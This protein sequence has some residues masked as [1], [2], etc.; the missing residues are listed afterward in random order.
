M[1]KQRGHGTG[2]GLDGYKLRIREVLI[3]SGWI[4]STVFFLGLEV[5]LGDIFRLLSYPVECSL[6]TVHFSS[7]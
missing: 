5:H 4:K 3:P 2:K 7:H 1:L 6:F